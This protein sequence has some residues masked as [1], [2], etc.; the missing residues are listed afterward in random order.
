[1]CLSVTC[2]YQIYTYLHITVYKYTDSI[3]AI[4]YIQC[5]QGLCQFRQCS[6]CYTLPCLSSCHNGRLVTGGDVGLTAA[7]FKPFIQYFIDGLCFV[8]HCKHLNYDDF[9]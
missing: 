6:A 3:F 9:T 1:M 5:K 2:L 8:L 4:Y 7:K